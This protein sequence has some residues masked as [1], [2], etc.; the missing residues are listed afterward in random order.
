MVFGRHGPSKID[1][2]ASH[3]RM[4]IDAAWKHNH[5]RGVDRAAA[6]NRVGDAAL[7]D[8]DVFDDAIQT[9]R[10]IVNFS[11]RNPQ[12]VGKFGSSLYLALK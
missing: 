4:H 11:A 7:G 1:R 10:G 12:H 6:L 3:V 9:V 8:A 2:S 5:A